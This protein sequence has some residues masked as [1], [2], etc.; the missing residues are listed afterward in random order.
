MKENVDIGSSSVAKKR[1]VFLVKEKPRRK[2]S[3]SSPFIRPRRHT[4]PTIT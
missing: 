3:R 2:K 4:E 1:S